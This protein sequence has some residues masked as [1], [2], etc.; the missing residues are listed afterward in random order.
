MDDLSKVTQVVS[1]TWNLG[2]YSATIP[3]LFHCTRL[4]MLH[5]EFEV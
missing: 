2:S 5:H 4:D 3:V 1:E